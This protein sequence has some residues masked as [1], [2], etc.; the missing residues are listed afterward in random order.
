MASE[1]KRVS[2]FRSSGGTNPGL[3]QPEVIRV[4]PVQELAGKE[5]DLGAV[6]AASNRAEASLSALHRAIQH[7]TDG[8]VDARHANEHL[9]QELARVRDMLGASNAQ[10]LGLMNQVTL[11]QE[12]LA[13]VRI[14]AQKEREFLMDDQDRFLAGLLEDHDVQLAR[15]LRDRDAAMAE[16]AD[17]K[18]SSAHTHPARKAGAL[19]LDAS[20]GQL[21]NQLEKLTLA[22]E[23][24]RETLRRLQAQRDDAHAKVKQLEQH[25]A[26][27]R[28]EAAALRAS[29]ITAPPD[30]RRT[31]PAASTQRNLPQAEDPVGIGDRPTLDAEVV[32]RATDPPAPDELAQAIVASRPTPP[33]G[34]GRQTSPQVPRP[35]LETHQGRHPETAAKAP[36]KRKPDPARSPLG[37]Y[38]VSG[39][40]VDPETLISSKPP[41]S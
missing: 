8:V 13:E 40:E 16:V 31:V 10:R 30:A 29:G 17:L 14:G 24:A 2:E 6:L 32:Q 41:R 5:N 34:T 20:P 38:S 9:N 15:V 4:D 11:L 27:A 28:Q 7:V 1:P 39:D 19:D 12:E 26:D 25:L 23:A 21:L 3:G 33:R 37:G 22:Q 18:L 35:S 36:L